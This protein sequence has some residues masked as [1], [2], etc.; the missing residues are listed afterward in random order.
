M[1]YMWIRVALD[2]VEDLS[3]DSERDRRIGRK[4]GWFIS[5]FSPAWS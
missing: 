5:F 3:V 1:D 2:S 4:V